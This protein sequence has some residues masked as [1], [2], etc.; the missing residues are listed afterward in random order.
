M[1]SAAQPWHA[2]A[3]PRTLNAVEIHLIQLAMPLVRPFETAAGTVEDRPVVLVGRTEDNATGWGEAAPYPAMTPD[4]IDGV[5][6]GLTGEIAM[7]PTGNAALEEA[8]ADLAAR[9]D[10]VPLWSAV[11]GSWRPQPASLAIG[12][13]EDPLERIETVAPA[14]VKVKI[15]PGEDVGRVE[16]VRQFHVYSDPARD[17]RGHTVSVVFIGRA[18]GVPKGADDAAEARAFP[19]GDLPTELAFDHGRILAD[20][21]AGRY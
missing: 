17:P 10:G 1:L 9:R 13:G 20:Y 11:G 3:R 5:W 14:A 21:L 7:T 15:R 18:A 8:E 2:I 6:G 16:L 12:L 19:R 4:T